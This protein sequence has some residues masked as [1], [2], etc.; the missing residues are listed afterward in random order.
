MVTSM[1]LPVNNAAKLS[2]NMRYSAVSISV[3]VA[4]A[5]TTALSCSTTSSDDFTFLLSMLKCAILSLITSSSVPS[6][7][8]EII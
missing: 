6:I 5:S 4:V 7:F 3:P 8:P 1:T 2:T